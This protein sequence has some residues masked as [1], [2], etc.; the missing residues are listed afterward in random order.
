MYA[1]E[2]SGICI[3]VE[4][5]DSENIKEN[6]GLSSDYWVKHNVEYK[7]EPP[8]IKDGHPSIDEILKIKSP[9]WKHEQ[10]VRYVTRSKEKSYLKV[11]IKR[12]L[13][14]V[15]AS[16]TTKAII[17]GIKSMFNLKFEVVDMQSLNANVSG[18][19]FWKKYD[20]NN[21]TQKETDKNKTGFQ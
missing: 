9:Q 20:G 2:H 3:E 21:F 7:N 10:E 6:A 13:I 18:V 12:V 11:H 15:R 8:K 4:I 16:A 17:Y 19:N 14:G 1:D 5:Q